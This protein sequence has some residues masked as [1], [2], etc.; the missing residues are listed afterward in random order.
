MIG[1]LMCVASI[2][3]SSISEDITIKTKKEKLLLRNQK[4]KERRN[5]DELIVA[6][7]T[8]FN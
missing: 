4:K 3:L 2:I 7:S 1:R 5:N 6:R 8:F